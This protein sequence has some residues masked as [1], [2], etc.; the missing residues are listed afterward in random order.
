MKE[1]RICSRCG[2][3][4]EDDDYIEFDGEILCADCADEY[5]AVCERCGERIWSDYANYF[6]DEVMCDEC[7][8]ENTVVCD[9]CGS[10]IWERDAISDEEL[11]ICECCYDNFYY[12][13]NDC[14]RLIHA[15]DSYCHDGDLYCEDCYDKVRDEDAIHDY[16]YK[17][18]PIF[19]GAGNRFFGVELEIDG[20]G[21]D[22]DNA[23]KILEITNGDGEERVYCKHDGSLNDGFEI[24]T[25]PMT[26][27][28]H[29]SKMPWEDITDK[30]IDMGYRSHQTSTCGLHV[31]VNRSALADTT[32][33][34]DEVIQKILL[35]VELHW[36]EMLQFSRRT[37]Y[38]I[39]RWAARYGM[40]KT[41]KE[42]LDK[43]KKSGNG[44]YAAI[45]LCN[46]HTIE[47][48]LFR[49]TLKLNTIYATLQLVNRIIDIVKNNSEKYIMEQSWSEFV[50]DIFEPELI[51]Y[52]RERRIY[53]NEEV[54]TEEEV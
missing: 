45:N 28:Y 20:E 44:R 27:D 50:A 37:Q 29:M 31:H 24:V 33:D 21:E 25:H 23:R 14:G 15:D 16:Y 32:G 40:E 2:C 3:V 39:D 53:I 12:R 4:I 47:F 1:E 11:T 7:F 22:N 17:P 46:Y 30:A 26:L 43:A 51:Q 18:D 34:Q 19:Y 42:L 9:R 13:C 6:D 10:R 49:G 54:D 41:G 35:F 8:D 36:A 5:T 48:R 52:L 38:S